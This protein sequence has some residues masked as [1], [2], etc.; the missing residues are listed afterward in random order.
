MLPIL[1]SH[2]Q[3][4]TSNKTAEKYKSYLIV[5]GRGGLIAE[6]IGNRRTQKHGSCS[7]RFLGVFLEHFEN[8]T[9]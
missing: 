4:R 9:A 8:I 5:L 6:I 7:T 1:V 3:V 2:S